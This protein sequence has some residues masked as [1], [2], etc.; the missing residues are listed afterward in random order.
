MFV[1]IWSFVLL[2]AMQWSIAQWQ[3]LAPGLELGRFTASDS[4]KTYSHPI[5]ILRVNPNFYQLKLLSISEQ[6]HRPLTAKQWAQKY[7]LIAV[8][9]AGMFDT[10]FKTHVGFMKNFDHLNNPNKNN[11]QSVAAFNPVDSRR[12][13]FMIFDLDKVSFD[14]ILKQYQCLIQ[15]LRLIRRPGENRW[16]QQNKKWSEAA[17]GQDRD[18]NVLLIFSRAP[19]SMHDFNNILLKLPI[20]LTCAQHLEGGPEASLYLKYGKV[21][22]KLM[23]SFESGFN[24]NDENMNFWPIPNVLGMVPKK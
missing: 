17:L 13:P 10:D 24:E 11:Y 4:L 14:Q 1:R 9:N 19:Y 3:P 16:K 5:V 20:N 7:N 6:N 22:L 15:N 2:F 21:E 23:G 12:S 8:T 18:G